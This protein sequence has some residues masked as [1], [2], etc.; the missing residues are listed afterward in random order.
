M[1][2][3][4]TLGRLRALESAGH[5]DEL[6]VENWPTRVTMGTPETVPALAAYEGF[7]GWARAHGVSMRPAFDRHDCHSLYTDSRFTA[8]VF[9]VMCLAVYEDEELR[10][11]FPHARHGR[12]VTICDGIAML[13]T[14]ESTTAAGR[15][16][17]PTP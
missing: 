7:E 10:S 17:P 9:P 14:D 11:V 15:R 12:S 3:E 4:K 6:V 2:Q 13:E 8:T 5:V 1:E 16:S